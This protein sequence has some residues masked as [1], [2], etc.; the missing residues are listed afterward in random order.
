MGR[1]LED[2]MA[3]YG[4]KRLYYGAMGNVHLKLGKHFFKLIIRTNL[5]NGM[6]IFRSD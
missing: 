1:R 2:D 5:L 6:I 3:F 4:R